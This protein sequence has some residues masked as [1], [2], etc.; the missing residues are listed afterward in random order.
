MDE[1]VANGDARAADLNRVE[2]R[3]GNADVLEGDVLGAVDFDAD[4]AADHGDVANGDVVGGDDD[5]TPHDGS[6]IAD[7]VLRMVDDERALVDPGLKM[8]RRRLR[9]PRDA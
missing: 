1:A 4:L 3:A 6:G 8:N 5:S 7:Q 9:R 2:A